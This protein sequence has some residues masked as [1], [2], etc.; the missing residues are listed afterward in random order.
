MQIADYPWQLQLPGLGWRPENQHSMTFLGEADAARRGQG[1]H[2]ENCCSKVSTANPVQILVFPSPPLLTHF[3]ST[4]HCSQ[5]AATAP[6]HQSHRPCLQLVTISQVSFLPLHQ[7]LFFTL[8]K[9]I[10]DL[11]LS[12]FPKSSRPT[13]TEHTHSPPTTRQE[14]T[15]PEPQSFITLHMVLSP[16]PCQEIQAY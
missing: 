16:Y 7:F 8:S 15:H 11:S 4:T 12:G 13:I 2:L 10:W 14:H 3:N 1:A 5:E 9:L 6:V